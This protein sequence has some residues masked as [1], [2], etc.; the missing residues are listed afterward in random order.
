MAA[1]KEY[2]MTYSVSINSFLPTTDERLAYPICWQF[3]ENTYG[4]LSVS[5]DLLQNLDDFLG[6]KNFA[7]RN[8]LT[9][10]NEGRCCHY[11]IGC[12]L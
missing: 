9:V 4:Q 6:F 3:A 12:N 8:H 1:D 10:Y 11:T 2:S 5:S 7:V